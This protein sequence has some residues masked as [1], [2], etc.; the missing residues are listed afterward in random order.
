MKVVLST[1]ITGGIAK[2]GWWENSK[3]NSKRGG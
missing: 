1:T 2:F 3:E